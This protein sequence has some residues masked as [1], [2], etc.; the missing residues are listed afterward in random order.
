MLRSFFRLY[1]RRS[2]NNRN[3]QGALKFLEPFVLAISS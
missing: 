1:I 2:V 3:V